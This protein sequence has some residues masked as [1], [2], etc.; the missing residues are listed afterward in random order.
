MPVIVHFKSRNLT[1]STLIAREMVVFEVKAAHLGRL[2]VLVGICNTLPRPLTAIQYLIHCTEIV[3]DNIS[4]P[5]EEHTRL[6]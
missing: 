3:P 1:F 4:A 2:P 6:S 5:G